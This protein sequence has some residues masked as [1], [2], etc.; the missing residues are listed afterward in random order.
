ANLAFLTERMRLGFGVDVVVDQ[1]AAGLA[2]RGHDVTVYASYEDGT[3]ADR[4]Y[5]LQTLSVPAIRY[6]PLYD[7]E[8]ARRAKRFGLAARGHELFFIETPPFFALLPWLRDRAVAVDHGV[9]DTRGFSLPVR[10]NFAFVENVQQHVY[11][12]A[13]GH[14]VTVSDFLRDELPAG[15]Q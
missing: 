7:I 6:A 10:L 2:G 1:V 12:R 8:A 4:P 15:L 3:Y 14:I 11:F 5:R 9:V 13:A